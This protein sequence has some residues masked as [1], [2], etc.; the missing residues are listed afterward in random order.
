MYDIMERFNIYERARTRYNNTKNAQ[1]PSKKKK[2]KKIKE[3]KIL[4][5]I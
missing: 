4:M 3:R 2:P 5:N 1:P